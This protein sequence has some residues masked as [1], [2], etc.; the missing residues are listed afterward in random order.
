MNSN[1]LNVDVAIVG[2]GPSGMLLA[3]LLKLNGISSALV[4]RQSMNHVL[5]RIRAGVLEQGSVDMMKLADIG[6]RVSSE[7]DQHAG[8][9]ITYG[10]D[11]LRIDLEKL[12]GKKVTVYGQTEV[13][14]DLYKVVQQ[15][16]IPL[17]E[18]TGDSTRIEM[19]ND[20]ATVSGTSNGVP[21]SIQASFVAGCDG[22][23]GVAR[24]TIPHNVRKDFERVYPFG[25]LGIL[26]ETKPAD[27]E[28]IYASDDEG[29][30][31]C[32]MRN[33]RL[34]RYYVQCSTQDKAEDW[35]DERFWDVLRARI[36]SKIAKH[37]ETGPSIEKSIA[38]LRSF[39]CEP[40]QYKRLFL[41]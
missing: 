25:W 23:H 12:T 30:A 38:P 20:H 19:D 33:E 14:K 28:L 39:V 18:E 3:R 21:F 9:S 27:H 22:F 32:S 7:G 17:F 16:G 37:M 35:S 11:S 24:K 10:N 29:F 1:A 8:F 36:P 4:E 31:L 26:S 15:D 5:S 41:C 6:D 2:A 40:I 34:S 13:T